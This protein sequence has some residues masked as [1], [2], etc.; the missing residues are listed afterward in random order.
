[1]ADNYLEKKQDALRNG[2]SVYVRNTPSLDTLIRRIGGP[3]SDPSYEIK[4]AQLDAMVR[5][6]LLYSPAT[7]AET[8]VLS[9]SIRFSG[10]CASQ[11]AAI[12]RLKA[13]EL[14]I[15]SEQKE[16]SN[17]FTLLLYK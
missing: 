11:A 15:R 5:S 12:A 3:V 9:G 13:A 6:A 4:Q 8:D 1:M 2:A 14:G 16:S 7:T 17:E 10:D